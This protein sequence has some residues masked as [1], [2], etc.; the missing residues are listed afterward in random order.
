MFCAGCGSKLAAGARFCTKCRRETRP[1]KTGYLSS[2]AWGLLCG[3]AAFLA[4]ILVREVIERY[5]SDRSTSSNVASIAPPVP[6]AAPSP[7]GHQWFITVLASRNHSFAGG[8]SEPA[9]PPVRTG[10]VAGVAV[11]WYPTRHGCEGVRSDLSEVE[12]AL[13]GTLAEEGLPGHPGPVKTAC[14]SEV[15]QAWAKWSP[16]TWV[17]VLGLQVRE[18]VGHFVCRS[19]DET[20]AAEE[21]DPVWGRYTSQP[22]CNKYMRQLTQALLSASAGHT[23]GQTYSPELYHCFYCVRGND[24]SLAVP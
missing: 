13:L 20:V 4:L 19:L 23:T 9:R 16:D 15:D 3:L 7:D 14:I 22:Q 11:G 1:E 18:T 24:P 10:E 6:A 2:P 17:G 8:R 5:S 21:T 12:V